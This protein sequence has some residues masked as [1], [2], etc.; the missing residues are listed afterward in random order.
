MLITLAHS[1]NRL[2]LTTH[3]ATPPP[4]LHLPFAHLRS[5][6]SHQW[7]LSHPSGPELAAVQPMRFP[8]P[9]PHRW[10]AQQPTGLQRACRL[11]TYLWR[12]ASNVSS[13][14]YLYASAESWLLQWFHLAQRR[15]CSIP[16]HATT[17][18]R[19]DS[20]VSLH[21]SYCGPWKKSWDLLASAPKQADHVLYFECCLHLVN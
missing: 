9:A 7:H 16:R 5:Y 21:C 15:L 6:V 11:L 20:C 3:V 2:I 1:A 4:H 10:L 17:R 14:F 18:T 8:T 12:A 19:N 13:C